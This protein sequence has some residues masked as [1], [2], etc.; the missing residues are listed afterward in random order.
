[1]KTNNRKSVS[2][3]TVSTRLIA[4]VAFA[5]FLSHA[6]IG[7]LAPVDLGTAG[8]YVILAKTGIS[9]VPA[10][11]VTGDIGVSPID[12][13]A[14]TGFSLILDSTTQFSKS[15]QV[16]GRVY[17][18]DYASPTAVNLTTAVSD[19]ATAYTDAAGR[20]LPDHTELG[21]GSIGGMTLAPGLYKWG[22][23][24]S[25]L[26]DVTLSGGP[27]DIWIFQISG[28]LTIASSTRVNLSGGAQAKN[29]FWQVAG[30]VGVVL[31]TTSHAEGVILAAKAIILNTG[32]SHNGRLLA[33][34]A[35]TLEANAVTAPTS[36]T[37]VVLHSASV[38]TGPYEQTSG[39][40]ANLETRTVTAPQQGSMKFY[41]LWSDEIL[42]VKTIT[43]SAGNVVITY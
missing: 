19:M 28:N 10:S 20:T 3:E 33:Q 14:I 30:G 36:P 39:Q 17:A 40:S 12:S 15:T 25:I 4:G 31:G 22:T 38:V 6:A 13:T 35:V 7:A 41:R 21:S 27:N 1:M 9:T 11:D 34:A 2:S 16:T 37:S 24:V 23:G 18:P 43:T 5:M 42:R 8:K 32:A 29:I 26:S